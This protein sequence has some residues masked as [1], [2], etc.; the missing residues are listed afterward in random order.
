MFRHTHLDSLRRLGWAPEL[1]QKRAGHANYQ[2]TVQEYY[3]VTD[4]E[5]R[6]A[7]EKTEAR[8]LLNKAKRG[9]IQ[10]VIICL[11][12]SRY[13]CLFVA[14]LKGILSSG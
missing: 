2:T 1:V 5:V 12:S 4:E 10:I 3:H 11:I 13:Q 14:L 6:E 9:A 8:I 7:W